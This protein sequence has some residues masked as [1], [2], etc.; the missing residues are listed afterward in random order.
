[1]VQR[2]QH[3]QYDWP[4]SGHIQSYEHGEYADMYQSMQYQPQ[5]YNQYPGGQDYGRFDGG[6]GDSFNNVI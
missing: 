2:Q 4:N 3:G 6:G 1:M 5:P